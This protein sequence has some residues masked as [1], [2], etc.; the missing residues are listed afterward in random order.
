MTA[1]PLVSCVIPVFNGE[2]YIAEAI[3]SVLSQTVPIAEI[4]VAD[5]GSD[6]GTVGVVGRFGENITY[7][8]QKNQGAPAARN[9]GARIASGEFIAFLDAD[10]LWIDDKT[11]RQLAQFRQHP[12]LGSCA[13]YM[14]NFWMPEV[15]EELAGQKRGRLTA[16]QAGTASTVMVRASTFNQIGPFDTT[17]RHRDVQDWLIRMRDR[18]WRMETLPDVLVRRRV[19]RSNMSR[20]RSDHGEQELLRLAREALEGRRLGRGK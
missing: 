7:V 18:G 9:Q 13:T 17:L 10:D 16:P 12:D 3:E 4:I 5:D 8:H 19:H 6:D 14:Q 11:E 1:A 15:A 20:N 2:R